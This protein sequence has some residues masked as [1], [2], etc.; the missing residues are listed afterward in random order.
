MLLLSNVFLFYRVV[1]FNIILYWTIKMWKNSQYSAVV[2]NKQLSAQKQTLINRL[3]LDLKYFFQL[4]RKLGFTSLIL[5]LWF[6]LWTILTSRSYFNLSVNSLRWIFLWIYI[7]MKQQTYF[8]AIVVNV[9]IFKL[10]IVV[11]ALSLQKQT[12]LNCRSNFVFTFKHI[13][14]EIFFY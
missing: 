13:R 2:V 8:F 9:V 14:Q 10:L 6:F 11:V 5:L 12:L 4:N 1:V 7:K 3:A